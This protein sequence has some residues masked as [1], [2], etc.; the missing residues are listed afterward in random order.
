LREKKEK[1]EGK[2]WEIRDCN[3]KQDEWKGFDADG[4]DKGR[5]S[6]IGWIE[7]VIHD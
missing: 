1:E 7:K 2:K 5:S 6:S 4:K 3:H